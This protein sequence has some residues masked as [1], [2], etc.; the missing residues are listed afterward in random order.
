MLRDFIAPEDYGNYQLHID[1]DG[2]TA[3]WT[4]FAKLHTG[5]PVLKVD[6][7]EKRRQWYYA[8]LVPWQNYVPIRSDLSD[9]AEQVMRLLEDPATAERIGAAGRSLARSMTCEVELTRAVPVVLA[10][11][12]N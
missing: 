5:S 6:S 2:N 1:I 8:R 4:G 12:Q 9:L 7:P 3:P 11:F 10:A